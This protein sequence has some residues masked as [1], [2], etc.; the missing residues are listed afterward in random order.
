MDE[1]AAIAALIALGLPYALATAIVGYW[2]AE[3]LAHRVDV[4]G[5]L[6]NKTQAVLLREK[7]AATK[8]QFVKKLLPVEAAQSALASYQI[9]SA[10][11]AALLAD[12]AAQV[13]KEALP[14]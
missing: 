14:P 3:K 5:V 7:V 8:E 6:L 9:P 10:N 2:S 12:W 11:I 1:A 4:F 13:L